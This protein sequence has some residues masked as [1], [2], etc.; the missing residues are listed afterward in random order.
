[1]EIDLGYFFGVLRLSGALCCHSGINE[2][3]GMI[4]RS[5]HASLVL[6][7]SLLRSSISA[8]Y[9]LWARGSME[10]SVGG[11]LLERKTLLLGSAVMAL[12]VRS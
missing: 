12:L 10:I 1:M 3:D 6:P 11:V 8:I 4:C 5:L 2:L 9:F 7:D